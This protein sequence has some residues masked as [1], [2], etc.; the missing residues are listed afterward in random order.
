MQALEGVKKSVQE[1][2]DGF[3]KK[4]EGAKSELSQ[5]VM[6]AKSPED[7]IALGKKLQAQGEALQLEEDG[8]KQEEAQ[9]EGLEANKAEMIKADQIEGFEMNETFDETKAAEAAAKEKMRV[10]EETA[11]IA[12]AEAT[13]LAAVRAKLSGESVKAEEAPAQERTEPVAAENIEQVKTPEESRY[14]FFK[15]SLKFDENGKMNSIFTILRDNPIVMLEAYKKNPENLSWVSKRLS[16]DPKFIDQMKALGAGVK[17][18]GTLAGSKYT[19][20]EGF[21][22]VD[23]NEKPTQEGFEKAK[24]EAV[25]FNLAKG[26]RSLEEMG[27]D[28]DF[29][30]TAI[31][32]GLLKS[33]EYFGNGNTFDNL[34]QIKRA[35]ES[36]D[37]DAEEMINDPDVRKKIVENAIPRM[38]GHINQDNSAKWVGKCLT[39][40]EETFNVTKSEW[41]QAEQNPVSGD[42]VRR[43]RNSRHNF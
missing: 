13:Q 41:D 11:A 31:K 32:D 5:E 21:R 36:I 9:G 33:L 34:E 18:D 27:V 42:S 40:L 12:E 1:K 3:K 37:G 2:W 38:C 29:A 25:A 23:A 35:M 26:S 7:L 28:K 17:K 6:S 30:R 43:Y 10:A 15:G 20:M 22:D 19:A 16:K 24:L 39:N 4:F 8:V 14:E